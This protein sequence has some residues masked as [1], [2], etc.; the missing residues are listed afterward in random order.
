M[1]TIL[2][3]RDDTRQFSGCFQVA[4]RIV[5]VAGL[6]TVHR[7][8]VSAQKFIASKTALP[9]RLGELAVRHAP[10]GK[11]NTRASDGDHTVAFVNIIGQ[12]L[13][14]IHILASF[15]KVHTPSPL[16][17]FKTASKT[18]AASARI[19]RSAS[20]IISATF[21][22]LSAETVAAYS[23]LSLRSVSPAPA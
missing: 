13:Y 17:P 21:L 11:G 22:M 8:D 23:M 14:L 4:Q 2:I 6:I 12:L 19:F 15:K 20:K 9:N 7:P 5:A 3:C 18:S 1:H 16:Y 10:S